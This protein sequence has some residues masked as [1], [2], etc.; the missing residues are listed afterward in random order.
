[1]PL[2][3]DYKKICSLVKPKTKILDLGCGNGELLAHLRSHREIEGTGIEIS[4]ENVQKAIA[5]G[6]SVIHGDLEEEIKNY[7]DKSFDYCILSQTLQDLRHPEE[8]L[9]EML[10]VSKRVLISFYNL[11]HYR[12]RFQILFTGRFP[13]SKDL[14]YKWLSTN[15][16]F[17]SIND[18]Q[19][20][21]RN[22]HIDIEES[23]YLVNDKIIRR[24]PQLRAKIAVFSIKKDA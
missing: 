6:L 16:F 11:A 4:L 8:V 24:W 23:I 3:L 7:P 9:L 17:L 22:H 15:V 1:M 21:C 13:K 14:P 5:E 20:L 19:D 18:F 2:R 12:Y 10:R